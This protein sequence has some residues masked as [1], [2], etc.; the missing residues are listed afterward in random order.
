M[1]LLS[2]VEEDK[3]MITQ[4]E[5]AIS[6]IKFLVEN[7]NGGDTKKTIRKLE[8][9]LLIAKKENNLKLVKML[10]EDLKILGDV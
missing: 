10:K 1:G 3:L 8:K 6:E 4:A 5:K 2:K 9:G 7:L